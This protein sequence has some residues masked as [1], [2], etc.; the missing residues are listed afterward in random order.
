MSAE[1]VRYALKVACPACH[2]HFE[3][4]SEPVAGS[5][6]ETLYVACDHCK[7]EHRLWSCQRELHRQETSD[8]RRE[9][10]SIRAMRRDEAAQVAAERLA[11]LNRE[12]AKTAA[13]KRAEGTIHKVRAFRAPMACSVLVVISDVVL[14]VGMIGVICGV[15]GL[16]TDAAWGEGAVVFLPGLLGSIATGLVIILGSLILRA[17]VGIWSASERAA[18]EGALSRQLLDDNL[19]A[20][21]SVRGTHPPT[22]STDT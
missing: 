16:F 11:V 10:K 4:E 13:L 12:K 15:A 3:V 8:N 21:A 14:T 7:A 6:V 9:A 1:P 2:K 5:E 19:R 17:I 22:A 18:H 20:L